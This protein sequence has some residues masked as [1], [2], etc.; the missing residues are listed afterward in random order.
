[1]PVNYTKERWKA[2]VVVGKERIL[3]LVAGKE[4]R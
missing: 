1:L 3:A 4:L 2:A